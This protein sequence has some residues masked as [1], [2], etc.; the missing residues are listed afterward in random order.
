MQRARCA[1]SSAAMR[2][3]NQ[4]QTANVAE[5]IKQ[6]RRHREMAQY[7]QDNPRAVRELVAG[8]PEYRRVWSE[9]QRFDR[10]VS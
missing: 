8:N 6:A 9:G 4:F 5:R 10:R 2:Q 7:L 1:R 3:L